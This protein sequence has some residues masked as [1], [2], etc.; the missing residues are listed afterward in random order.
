MFIYIQVKSFYEY[1]LTEYKSLYFIT[2]L[3]TYDTVQINK[4]I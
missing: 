4:H 2:S 3:L 1:V